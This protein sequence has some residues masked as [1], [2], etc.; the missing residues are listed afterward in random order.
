MMSDV[1]KRFDFDLLKI[2]IRADLLFRRV[3]FKV[4]L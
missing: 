4:N 1:N 2:I 3:E